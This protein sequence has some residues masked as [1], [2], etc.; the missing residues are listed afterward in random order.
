MQLTKKSSIRTSLTALTA[1]LLGAAAVHAATNNK[2]E[3][4][5]LLYSETNRVQAA[6][7]LFQITHPL[8][9]TRFITG[10]FAF[11]GLTGASPNGATPSN[12]IQTFTGPSGTNSYQIKPG[13]TP[14]DNTF[15][16]TRYAVD[17]TIGQELDPVTNGTIGAHFSTEHDYTSLGLNLGISRDFNKKNTTLAASLAFF[18]DIVRPVGGPPIPLT[19]MLPPTDGG[20]KGEGDEGEASGPQKSKNDI[21]AVLG[22]TQVLDRRT[23]FRINYSLS[24]SSGYLNDP[25]KILSVVGD[26]SST[27]PGEPGG[28]MYESRPDQ[29]TKNAAFAQLRRYISG[30]TI[31]F[32]YRYYWD[33]W[34]ITSHT[35]DLSYHLPIARGHAL[36]PH[37]RWYYQTEADFY[38]AYLFGGA[39]LP[40]HASADYRLSPF[41]ALTLG[42]QY[43]LPVGEHVHL[44]IGF[45]Y[46][47]QAGDLS[48]PDGLG[49]LSRY[50][51]FPTLDAA[52]V[53]LGYS[54]GL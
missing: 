43:L 23:I 7:G 4:S 37:A 14:L 12:S 13:E 8:K 49:A 51:L 44:S 25:Y 52:M 17:G 19:L 27:N 20:E 36:E 45:E 50:D 28:Y 6:E 38:Q 42:L 3:S 16:D 35:F 31:D 21:D 33:S 22:L 15:R 26:R 41:H 11:D 30:H 53:R 39:P 47:H 2:I 24:R 5:L 46:Y 1:S 29:R 18:H 9:G 10:R 48:P 54:Y 34:G 40:D 32:S